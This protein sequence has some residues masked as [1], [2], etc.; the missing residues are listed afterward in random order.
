[1][2]R[3]RLRAVFLD[4]GNT[5]LH[6]EPSRF[7]IYAE[8]A[9]AHGVAVAATEMRER[10][11]RAHHS[12][13]ERLDGHFRYSDAWFEAFIRAVF[14]A[15]GLSE[16]ALRT[17]TA[18]LFAR[19]EAQASFRLFPGARE[20]VDAVRAAGLTLGIISNW[21]ARLPRVL[22]AMGLDSSFDFV[23]C[24]A[25]EELEKPDPRLF[26]RA[27]ALAEVEPHE[28]LHAGDHPRLDVE[29]ARSVG[30]QA[31][32]VD[33]GAASGRTSDATTNDGERVSDL[34]A[35]TRLILERS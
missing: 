20:L 21:S 27:L 7:A 9:Q 24:S 10:M 34:Q 3:P 18:E 33:R 2:P 5:L 23:L 32:L 25:I 30:I 28:A 31:V 12:L 13:P 16:G 1:M 17:V 26:E 6:E 11:S 19:F 14:E 29:A 15:D 4:V 35:L 22:A 8:V